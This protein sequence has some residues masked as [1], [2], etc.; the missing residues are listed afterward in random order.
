MNYKAIIPGI[1]TT[2]FVFTFGAV[3]SQETPRSYFF[4]GD[5]VVFVFDIRDYEKVTDEATREQL[6]FSDFEIDKV[7]VTGE[8]SM[9][10][11]NGWIMEKTGE[12]TYQLRKKFSDFDQD[13]PIEFKY[14][15]NDQYWAEPGKAFPTIRKFDN[16]FFEETYN[17]TLYDVLPSIEGNTFF[18]LEGYEDAKQVILTGSFVEWDEAFLKMQKVPGGWQM[19]LD[20]RP[21]RYEYKYIV[22]G[23][24][25]HDEG[26]PNTVKNEHGT[27]NSVLQVVKL[28][29]FE[30]MGF[31]TAT[32]VA[33]VTSFNHWN[34]MPMQRVGDRWVADVPIASGKYHY[35]YAVDGR[36]ITDPVNP[37][38]ERNNKG[39][40]Y[41]VVI[42]Q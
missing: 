35:K 30:L 10:S 2:I 1:L 13:F 3:V 39:D 17:L 14:I 28:H 25:F 34:Q 32:Q 24:W 18:F 4:D 15:I 6:D 26:N 21:D 37:L 29:R 36:Y 22:D 42:V 12:Y 38:K 16:E 27:L 20:L 8:F 5:E 23:E 41:S 40:E 33:V 7:A 19:R 9:W 31:D 11:R